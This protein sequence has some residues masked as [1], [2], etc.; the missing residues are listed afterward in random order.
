MYRRRIEENSVRLLSV[1][2][3]DFKVIVLGRA[4]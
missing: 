2:L 3:I 1:T 4:K